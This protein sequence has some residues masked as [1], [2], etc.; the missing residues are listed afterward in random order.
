MNWL[1][2]K[3]KKDLMQMKLEKKQMIGIFQKKEELDNQN[4]WPI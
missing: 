2:K 4:V 1:N 3:K